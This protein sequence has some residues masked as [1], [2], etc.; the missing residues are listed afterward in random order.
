MSRTRRNIR[1]KDITG[2][3]FKTLDGKYTK[4]S[5]KLLPFKVI[6]EEISWRELRDSLSKGYN[7]KK[8]GYITIC[9]LFGKNYAMNGNHRLALL[10]K[11]RSEK[12]MVEVESFNLLQGLLVLLT[13]IIFIAVSVTI[14][15]V[16]NLIK[17][18]NNYIVP[19]FRI[20]RK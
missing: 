12:F 16:N 4:T 5:I 2:R 3:S 20:K 18:V 11:M 8:Y 19:V 10:K 1:L 13:V 6:R 9:R 17:I 14:H 7:P 15:I